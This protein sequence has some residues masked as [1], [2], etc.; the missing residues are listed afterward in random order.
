MTHNVSFSGILEGVTTKITIKD[1]EG[2]TIATNSEG[3]YAL[4]AGEYTCLVTS[5]KYED[6][7][8]SINVEDKDIVIPLTFKVA[9][10]I[11]W[12]DDSKDSFEIKNAAQFAG[13]AALANG[14]TG[15]GVSFKGKTIIITENIELRKNQNDLLPINNFSGTLDGKNHTIGGINITKCK[16]E[17]A[18]I[19]NLNNGTIKNI[20]IEGSI[21]IDESGKKVAGIVATSQNAII[22]NCINKV[23]IKS[24]TGSGG[25]V[26]YATS[27]TILNCKNTGNVYG[28]EKNCGG[29]VGSVVDSTKY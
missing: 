7:T 18:L 25:I 27:A 12:Y 5:D 20:T 8:G 19:A 17:A 11:S 1:K 3:T 15:E 16:S 2:N 14:E 10:D 28:T 6:I 23:S 29:I 13:I 4:K 22:E 9:Y 21:N 24:L 26:Q